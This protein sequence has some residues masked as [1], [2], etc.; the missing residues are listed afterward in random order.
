M[1]EANYGTFWVCRASGGSC[2]LLATRA[3]PPLPPCVYTLP[4]SLIPRPY[5]T[6]ILHTAVS[7]VQ[8]VGKWDFN[9]VSLLMYEEALLSHNGDYWRMSDASLMLLPKWIF[10]SCVLHDSQTIWWPDL[11]QC[12]PLSDCVEESIWCSYDD[13]VQT[14]NCSTLGALA[15]V[16]NAWV[17]TAVL[18]EHSIKYQIIKVRNSCREI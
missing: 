7:S 3:T 10:V 16:A 5:I 8:N 1:I 13:E 18:Q 17:H 9:G 4:L 12:F 14:K 6:F 11:I 15:F 2:A